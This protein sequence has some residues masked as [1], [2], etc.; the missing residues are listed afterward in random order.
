MNYNQ[1][2][3]AKRAREDG[4]LDPHQTHFNRTFNRK[5]KMR[6][7]FTK[8]FPSYKHS[9]P[10][11]YISSV[12]HFQHYYPKKDDVGNKMQAIDRT[13]T[14]KMDFIKEYSESMYKIKDMRGR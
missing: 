6:D 2:P 12:T 8:I 9:E 5:L 3:A 4:S 10:T 14:H 7:T 13:F 1:S 11:C